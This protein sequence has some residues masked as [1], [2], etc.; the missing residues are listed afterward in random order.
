MTRRVRPIRDAVTAF[1][2]LAF[3]WLIAAKLNDG[4]EVSHAGRFRAADGDSL[5]LGDERM[6]LQGIDAPELAQTCERGGARWACGQEAR[7]MLQNLVA[8]DDARCSGTERDRFQRLLVVCRAGGTDLNATMVRRGMAVS[9][10]GYKQEETQARSERLGLWA[11]T[12]DMPRVFRD[13]EGARHQ[14]RGG[15]GLFGW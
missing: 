5:V 6:R 11:G 10:G 4:A 1:A 13:N 9:Y 14:V 7:R 12:F 15:L 3:I 8:R 2:L